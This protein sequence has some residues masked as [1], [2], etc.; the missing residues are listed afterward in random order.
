[1]VCGVASALLAGAS[2]GAA[3]QVGCSLAVSAARGTYDAG[4]RLSG[5][6]LFAGLDVTGGPVRLWASLPVIRSSSSVDALDPV[7]GA[8]G[9]T[10]SISTGVGDPLVR[11]DVRLVDDRANALQ[12]SVAASVKPSLVDPAGGL[13]TGETDV[14]FGGSLFKAF[15][16][17]SVF[18]DALYW[19]YGDPE[20]LDYRDAVI[21]S[22]GFG[23]V[24]GRSRWSSMVSLSGASQGA[25]GGEPPMQINVAALLPAGDRQSLAI[26]GSIGL[27]GSTGGFSLS[28]SWRASF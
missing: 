5:L 8:P 27:R 24:I 16:R 22:V 14:A 13:G 28:T 3:Q 26:S 23:R 2:P 7:S 12:V 21:Y 1:M 9:S 15:G 6:Y 18:A 25:D 19:K 10:E 11:V 4:Y 17:T 20:G